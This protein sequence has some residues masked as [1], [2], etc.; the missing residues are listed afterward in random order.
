MI[1]RERP[2]VSVSIRECPGVFESPGA[3]G[4]IREFPRVSECIREHPRVSDTV[5]KSECV[6]EHQEGIRECPRPCESPSVREYPRVSGIRECQR[7]R[8]RPRGPRVRGC[9]RLFGSEESVRECL[10][11]SESIRECPRLLSLSAQSVRDFSSPIAESVRD[12]SVRDYSSPRPS[13]EY[14]RPRRVVEYPRE[15]SWALGSGL[16]SCALRPLRSEPLGPTVSPDLG[17][18]LGCGSSD[19]RL[20]K[21]V[22]KYPRVGPHPRNV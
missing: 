13:E 20:S 11:V 4:S 14:P 10:R 1:I 18:S 17:Y 7:P 22:R 5:R 16:E 15:M 12:T 19:G 3:P 6:R 8:E 9:P 2:R 21:S